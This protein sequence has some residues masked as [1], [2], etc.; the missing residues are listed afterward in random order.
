MP[1]N[2]KASEPV[3][4]SFLLMAIA[5]VAVAA[6]TDG[7]DKDPAH[8]DTGLDTEYTDTD[9]ADSAVDDTADSG[10]TGDTEPPTE[11]TLA[12][13]LEVDVGG[14]YANST[15]GD[16]RPISGAHSAGDLVL[17][18]VDPGSWRVTAYGP[19]MV[20]CNISELVELAAGDHL[21]WTVSELPGTMSEESGCVLPE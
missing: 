8:D 6:C 16:A 15:E 9:T 5:F 4:V 11:A 7:K 13:N 14:I 21:D 3:V 2:Y 17:A 10:E 12:I 20:A 18:H 1:N 19:D